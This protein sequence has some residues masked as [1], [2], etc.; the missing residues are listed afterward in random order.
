MSLG[1]FAVSGLLFTASPSLFA[2][3]FSA[4]CF[5]IGSI[6]YFAHR[7]VYFRRNGAYEFRFGLPVRACRFAS[8]S[9]CEAGQD[10]IR[11]G[12]ILRLKSGQ[13]W[14]V[15]GLM[16]GSQITEALVRLREAGLALPDEDDLRQR[17]GIG[18]PKLLDRRPSGRSA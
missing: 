3:R 1:F 6:A 11:E 10:I 9:H 14:G 12:L 15:P 17:L 8:V 13:G 18:L 4:F 5:G 7:R 16:P 2:L